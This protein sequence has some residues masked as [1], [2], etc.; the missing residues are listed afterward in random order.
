[1]Q[2]KLIERQSTGVIGILQSLFNLCHGPRREVALLIVHHYSNTYVTCTLNA[3]MYIHGLI[4]TYRYL[5][6]C[7]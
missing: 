1:M 5:S 3:I 7:F 2:K 4:M 6:S